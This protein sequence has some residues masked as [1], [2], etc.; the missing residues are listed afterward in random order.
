MSALE[1]YALYGAPLLMAAAGL[2]V[3]LFAMRQAKHDHP[4]ASTRPP[5]E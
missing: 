2:A 1:I 5:A 3:Y 4:P